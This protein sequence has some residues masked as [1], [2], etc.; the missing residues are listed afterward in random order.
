M[1]A[2]RFF[3]APQEP[4]EFQRVF[5]FRPTSVPRFFV[6]QFRNERKT[7]KEIDDNEHKAIPPTG[8]L[9]AVDGTKM[10]V[11]C[12][13]SPYNNLIAY[14]LEEFVERSVT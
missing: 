11:T 7:T 4:A 12:A 5:L 1:S 14:V 10:V 2:V 8:M 3:P 9:L 6:E 13:V